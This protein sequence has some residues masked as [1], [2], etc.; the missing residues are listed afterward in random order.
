MSSG[1]SESLK[2]IAPR[3]YYHFYQKTENGH[4]TRDLKYAEHWGEFKHFILFPEHLPNLYNSTIES[5]TETVD[6][7]AEL[8]YIARTY[9]KL[10]PKV[11]EHPRLLKIVA[12]I[13]TCLVLLFSAYLLLTSW[14]QLTGGGMGVE[15]AEVLG[16]IFA[17]VF[18]YGSI[19]FFIGRILQEYYKQL[20]KWQGTARPEWQTKNRDGVFTPWFKSHQKFLNKRGID[21]EIGKAI[22]YVISIYSITPAKYYWQEDEDSEEGAFML[23]F[24]VEDKTGQ[25]EVYEQVEAFKQHLNSIEVLEH[26][27]DALACLTDEEM[28]AYREFQNSAPSPKKNSTVLWPSKTNYIQKLTEDLHR[29]TKIISNDLI[30]DRWKH[31]LD[32][33]QFAS[34]TMTDNEGNTLTLQ[35]FMSQLETGTTNCFALRGNSGQGKTTFSLQMALHF[36]STE[37]S[38]IEPLIVKARHIDR[39][40]ANGSLPLIDKEFNPYYRRWKRA[41]ERKVLIVDGVD[42]NIR[43]HSKLIDRLHLT[44]KFYQTKL[45]FTGRLNTIPTEH[46]LSY[47]LSNFSDEYL[48]RMIWD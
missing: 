9:A 35:E 20:R 23:P 12:V 27:E 32:R 22:R 6:D 21:P 16:I 18:S 13:P 44:A 3:E 40:E 26:L 4:K 33:P 37:E 31:L 8:G 11:I 48:D 30:V 41:T 15:K 43:L 7:S 1:T 28:K 5:F 10:Y 14:E 42:E 25:T 38:S 2:D 36:L 46:F 19:L 45:L 29:R 39:I 24:S 17:P 47:K 34:R